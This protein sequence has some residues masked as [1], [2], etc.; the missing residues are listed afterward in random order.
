MYRAVF[1]NRNEVLKLLD[2]KK[3]NYRCV[4]HPAV[5]TMEQMHALHLDGDDLIAKNLFL[6]DDK[7]KNYYL[8][9][10]GT[11]DAVNLKE[12]RQVIG[13]RPLSFASD[14]DLKKLLNLEKGSVTPLGILNDETCMVHFF[15]D[16]RFK[17]HLIGVH[18]M[19]NTATVWLPAEDLME[20]LKEHGNP[21]QYI[22]IH[23]IL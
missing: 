13:S 23:Q 11:D 8:I 2:Q 12:L 19:E 22:Q 17:N 1:M 15:A 7:K 20:L 6:R 14:G 18:P 9:S 4:D 10:I 16:L 5:Y 3:I 21:V